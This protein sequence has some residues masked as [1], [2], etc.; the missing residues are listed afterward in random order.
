[1]CSVGHMHSFRKATRKR[2]CLKLQHSDLDTKQQ[3]QFSKDKRLS[4]TQDCYIEKHIVLINKSTNTL[5][6]T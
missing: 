1:M 3:T 6:Y 2:V 5:I 4:E